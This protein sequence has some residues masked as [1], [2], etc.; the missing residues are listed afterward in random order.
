VQLFRT[1]QGDGSLTMISSH[2]FTG[3]ASCRTRRRVASKVSWSI[4]W[5][6][7]SLPSQPGVQCR[8]ENR[9]NLD[10]PGGSAGGRLD[11]IDGNS[12]RLPNHLTWRAVTQSRCSKSPQ[13]QLIWVL[14]N[15][16]VTHWPTCGKRW[17]GHDD[18][19]KGPASASAPCTNWHP[20]RLAEARHRVRREVSAHERQWLQ[21]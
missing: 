7:R 5:S 2:C 19:P 16:R 17:S 15:G 18:F 4:A 1:G 6:F 9:Q 8:I 3:A 21:G 11:K 10:A 12:A 13:T 20:S 14:A